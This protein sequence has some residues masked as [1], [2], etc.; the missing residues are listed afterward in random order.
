MKPIYLAAVLPVLLAACANTGANYTPILDGRPNAA[1]K[2]DLAACQNLARSQRQFDKKTAGAAALGAGAGALLGAADDDGSAAGGAV[3]GA[4]GGGAAGMVNS[5]K[6]RKAIVIEC[7][8]G[9]GHRVV[10]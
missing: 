9:R 1:Y 4:L 8:K 6:Q 7:L 10:G 5:S 3:V 2:V